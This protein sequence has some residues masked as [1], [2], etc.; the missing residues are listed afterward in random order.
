MFESCV[1]DIIMCLTQCYSK[2]RPKLAGWAEAV[3]RALNGLVDCVFAFVDGTV[4]IVL[5]P[6]KGQR[7]F[8]NGKEKVCLCDSLGTQRVDE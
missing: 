5:R 7:L 3:S 1:T 2:L 8:F 6:A 4:R